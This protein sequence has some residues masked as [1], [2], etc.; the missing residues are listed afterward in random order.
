M[1][2][3]HIHSPVNID[4]INQSFDPYLYTTEKPKKLNNSCF[5][6][7]AQI[8]SKM[9]NMI[10]TQ[11]T[12]QK[13]HKGVGGGIITSISLLEFSRLPS[14]KQK[15]ILDKLYEEHKIELS[16]ILGRLVQIN[17]KFSNIHGREVQA[18]L[19][20][21]APG[22][23]QPEKK[24]R[25]QILSDKR[26]DGSCNYDI[27]TMRTLEPCQ[28]RKNWESDELEEIVQY[29]HIEWGTMQHCCKEYSWTDDQIYKLKQIFIL[30]ANY[31]KSSRMERELK[32]MDKGKIREE[33]TSLDI[34]AMCTYIFETPIKFQLDGFNLNFDNHDENTLLSHFVEHKNLQ[35]LKC[36]LKK[37]SYSPTNLFSK[38]ESVNFENL[39]MVMFDNVDDS[40][41]LELISNPII[42][43]LYI[44]FRDEYNS[45]NSLVK[46]KLWNSICE[47][48]YKDE[49]C[50]YPDSRKKEIYDNQKENKNK[51][52]KLYSAIAK[53]IFDSM[54]VKKYQ[55]KFGR[56]EIEELC[57]QFGDYF[58]LDTLQ[59]YAK[60]LPT[61]HKGKFQLEWWKQF[62]PNMR[63]T[64]IEWH[65]IDEQLKKLNN[66][67][68]QSEPD[69]VIKLKEVK[70]QLKFPYLYNRDAQ[71]LYE[72][73]TNSFTQEEMKKLIESNELYRK[74]EMLNLKSVIYRLVSICYEGTH[75]Q[76]KEEKEMFP[77]LVSI[78]DTK[79]LCLTFQ[80]NPAKGILLKFQ[81]IVSLYTEQKAE[82][83]ITQQQIILKEIF[84]MD[85]ANYGLKGIQ[86]KFTQEYLESVVSSILVK[87]KT[88]LKDLE[89]GKEFAFKRT[90]VDEKNK[91]MKLVGFEDL[92]WS[93]HNEEMLLNQFLKHK[94][95][96]L[97]EHQ[98]KQEPYTELSQ[99]TQQNVELTILHIL[100]KNVIKYEHLYLRC[101]T[102]QIPTQCE[103]QD[104]FISPQKLR[105]Y[106][107]STD[108]S[109]EQNK[110]NK[111]IEKLD[112]SDPIQQD[113][114]DF[115]G[116]TLSW[117][118]V[119]KVLTY[120]RQTKHCDRFISY[121]KNK[122]RLVDIK[123]K[124][125]IIM[126]ALINLGGICSDQELNIDQLFGPDTKYILRAVTRRVNTEKEEKELK[127]LLKEGKI[128]EIKSIINSAKYCSSCNSDS[129]CVDK[130]QCST[131]HDI[132][133]ETRSKLIID[134]AYPNEVGTG[135]ITTKDL[136]DAIR[137][138]NREE[139]KKFIKSDGFLEILYSLGADQI[140]SY[141]RYSI[142][143]DQ[144]Y[145]KIKRFVYHIVAWGN[146]I[147]KYPSYANL[148]HNERV[149]RINAYI[150]ASEAQAEKDY[151]TK[152][153]L[154]VRLY[155]KLRGYH[156]NISRRAFFTSLKAKDLKDLQQYAKK[157]NVGTNMS[158]QEM[159]TQLMKF[160]IT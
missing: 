156:D 123:K 7:E 126:T 29:Y 148:I 18:I 95:L 146:L 109:S 91:D 11:L 149:E 54:I 32:L 42:T 125:S 68:K 19:R 102:K 131:C 99:V 73:L 93:D 75:I 108:K 117:T 37:S 67:I 50:N 140:D 139:F 22:N 85:R 104:Q 89:N 116:T 28:Y 31:G 107:Q 48:F 130:I 106:K 70:K 77:P 33:Y 57:S 88:S 103:V 20:L 142:C 71:T 2:S 83:S 9:S 138:Q 82:Y 151:I 8:L 86:W 62:F 113:E 64:M 90:L 132:E 154:D 122:K 134:H 72:K 84:Q 127:K 35:L 1:D 81:E 30:R 13:T 60:T 3:N 78:H 150:Q 143:G 129:K 53:Y 80:T 23:S 105:K 153:P 66:S 16:I 137:Q 135:F 74:K 111:A 55:Y 121:L 101:V 115:V 38:A 133:M 40:S 92:D 41:L 10:Y 79:E 147:D 63:N 160:K 56:S 145:N 155:N 47:G 94:N 98:L 118:T 96:K 76:E 110:L 17:N 45:R 14:Q 26:Y 159:Y 44:R 157:Q 27:L 12:N 69:E 114:K 152:N 120:I 24:A 87:M 136:P 15:I 34:N 39:F 5:E 61:L 46:K 128:N 36:Q 119:L 25:L 97:I 65:K 112:K 144:M 59:T 49:G 158:S 43:Q 58:D 100:V 51:F 4:P 6:R 141:S 52:G 124:R 21:L